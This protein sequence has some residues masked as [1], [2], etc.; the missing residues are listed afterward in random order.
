MTAAVA[1]VAPTAGAPAAHR[2]ARPGAASRVTVRP[3]PQREP[4]FDDEV[5]GRPLVG[6]YD[7]RLPFDEPTSPWSSAIAAL[8]RRDGLPEPTLWAR[9]LLVGLIETA[10]GRRPLAQLTAMLSPSIGRGLG[11]DFE[12]AAV[13]GR[14]HWLHRAHVATVRSAEAAAGIAE[15]C[16]TVEVGPRVRAVALRLEVHRGRWLCTRLQLG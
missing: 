4:P 3:A 15:L 10:D 1:T 6:R 2:P 7:Q 11:A 9:R 13:A 5:A 8:P 12:R 14:P 16:A